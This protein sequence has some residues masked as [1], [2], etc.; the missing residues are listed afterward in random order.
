MSDSIKRGEDRG[1]HYAGG[2]SHIKSTGVLV[3]NLEKNPKRYQDP[4]L[5]EGGGG[6]EMVFTPRRYQ[7]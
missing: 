6:L 4:V 2:D 5:W 1:G 3:G 7:F